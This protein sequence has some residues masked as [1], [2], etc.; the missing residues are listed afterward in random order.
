[1]ARATLEGIRAGFQCR[2]LRAVRR[3][4]ARGGEQ[5]GSGIPQVSVAPLVWHPLS[6]SHRAADG[7]S[8]RGS[9][10]AAIGLQEA[11]AR[12]ETEAAVYAEAR[13]ARPRGASTTFSVVG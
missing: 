5:A 6:A 3:M 7:P 1:R 8:G 2:G 4:D 13:P 10:G 11:P 12:S 9:R